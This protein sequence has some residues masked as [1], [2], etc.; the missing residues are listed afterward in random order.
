VKRT[1]KLIRAWLLGKTPLDD[2]ATL[3]RYSPFY[4]L[5]TVTTPALILFGAEDNVASVDQGWMYYRALKQTEKTDVRF[6]L[7]PSVGHVPSKPVY[8]KR[9]MSE[10]LGWFD[11]YLWRRQN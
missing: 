7:F 10:E 5:N 1:T 4:Q 11:K 2:S 6:V 9:A 3:K 8:I